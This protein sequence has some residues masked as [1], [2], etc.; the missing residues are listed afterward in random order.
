MRMM[1]I[2]SILPG[3]KLGKRIYSDE[4]IVLLAEGVELTGN[5]LRRLSEKGIHY[6]Y[7][8]D[9]RTEGIEAPE[10]L[11]EETSRR[12]LQTLRSVF[13]DL[14]DLPGKR[15]T[16]TYPYVGKTVRQLMHHVLDDLQRNRDALIMLMNMHT[17]DHYLYMHSLNVCVYTVLLG[18][19]H[20]YGSDELM[21][22]GLGALL[23]DIGKTQISMNVLMKPGRLTP[24]EYDEMKRHAERG[25]YL[26][27]DEPNIPLIVA[28]CA[29]QH[30][31]RLNGTGYPRGLKSYEIH[32]YAK[33]IG[34]VDSYDAMTSH[35]IYKDPL[36]PHQAIETLYAG[37]GTLYDTS[38]LKIFRDKVAIY[39][40]GISVILSTG[41]TAIVVD[42]N[43]ASVH[44]PIVRV[45]TDEN[46]ADLKV[47]YDLDLSKHLSV[48]IS[49]IDAGP[50]DR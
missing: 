47:P 42:I 6:L 21:T 12:A 18:M 35:R 49:K 38:M 28:H 41:Q 22:I 15:H 17:V 31:E 5:L 40:V 44:R 27:K 2:S 20:G 11:S 8:Q 7:V 46:G 39:P 26:L 24:E 4:G 16:G 19:A 9:P 23:H 50:S 34:I 43:S 30:H 3:M 45:I 29:Y 32:E 25:Y 33:W 14:V 1:P 36:L 48:M 10:L 13:R 37:S